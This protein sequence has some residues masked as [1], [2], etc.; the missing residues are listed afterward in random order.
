MWWE[1][2]AKYRSFRFR[3]K[4]AARNSKP[5]KQQV[6]K[7]GTFHAC[8]YNMRITAF[9]SQYEMSNVYFCIVSIS[10]VGP[11]IQTELGINILT[12]SDTE[13]KRNNL[14]LAKIQIQPYSLVNDPVNDVKWNKGRHAPSPKFPCNTNLL[15]SI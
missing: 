2:G 11:F 8:S 7:F 14:E 10:R 12:I 5:D 6:S 15:Q 13:S 4:E 1:G 3:G 9:S